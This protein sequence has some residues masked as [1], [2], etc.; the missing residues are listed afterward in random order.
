M[1]YE[2]NIISFY[3]LLCYQFLTIGLVLLIAF[4]LIFITLALLSVKFTLTDIVLTK[5][6]DMHGPLYELWLNPTPE[7]R[8]NAYIFTVENANEFLNGTDSKI[9]IKEIGPVVYREYLQHRDVVFH[10]NSTLS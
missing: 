7:L 4:G 9:K 3:S 5:R 2:P 1:R 6:L 10:E 8:L